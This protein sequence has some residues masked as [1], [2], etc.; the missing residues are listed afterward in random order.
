MRHIK[1]SLKNAEFNVRPSA[2]FAPL[3]RTVTDDPWEKYLTRQHNPDPIFIHIP[4]TA[5]TS[6]LRLFDFKVGHVPLTRYYSWDAERASKAFKFAFVRNPW[7]RMR[8]GYFFLRSEYTKLAV[9]HNPDS[10]QKFRRD[11]IKEHVISTAG[12]ENF[13]HSM[14]SKAKRRELENYYIFRPQHQWIYMPQEKQH[15]MQFVGRFERINEDIEELRSIF[16]LP[17]ILGHHRA[18]PEQASQFSNEMI[19]IIGDLYERDI[20]TFNYSE[21]DVQ[22]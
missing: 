7:T 12:F 14:K 2:L 11:W 4:K 8:S 1:E 19:G 16:K 9:I 5:G 21:L 3:V 6:V 17:N 20:V 13:V 18:T 10:N 15:R 22:K